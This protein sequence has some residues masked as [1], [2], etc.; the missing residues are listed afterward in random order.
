[1]R[2][3]SEN[4]AFPLFRADVGGSSKKMGGGWGETTAGMCLVYTSL[5]TS[6]K[7]FLIFTTTL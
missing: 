2:L 1:M 7:L 4:V 3:S 5:A 6:R